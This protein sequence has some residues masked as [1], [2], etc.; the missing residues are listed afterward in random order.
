MLFTGAFAVFE[1]AAD[2]YENVA[3]RIGEHTLEFDGDIVKSID[4]AADFPLLM[5]RCMIE[6]EDT[7]EPVFFWEQTDKSPQNIKFIKSCINDHF[8]TEDPE[9][10]LKMYNILKR[11]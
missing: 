6:D 4:L 10:L 11:Q 3:H 7:E 9:I 8:D 5:N 1:N 2:F